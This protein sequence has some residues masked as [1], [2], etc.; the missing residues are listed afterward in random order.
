M[1]LCQDAGVRVMV[2]TGDS[3]DTATAIARDVNIF[4]PEDVRGVERYT[5]GVVGL[6]RRSKEKR[7]KTTNVVF[8]PLVPLVARFLVSF[9]TPTRHLCFVSWV[10]Q[11][12]AFPSSRRMLP[13]ELG[14][15]PISSGFPRRGRRLCWRLE[16]CS[17]AAPSPRTSRGS[18]RCSR[19]WERC[20]INARTMRAT[21]VQQS[22]FGERVVLGGLSCLVL[23]RVRL[24]GL[25]PSP[26]KCWC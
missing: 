4:G 22:G 17:S 3:K 8:W 2:I 13:I 7:N 23:S 9:L 21:K 12:C 18:S 25:K 5:M 26:P 1:K 6:C 10:P 24:C 14:S 19:T 15:E 11:T 20:D 16:T